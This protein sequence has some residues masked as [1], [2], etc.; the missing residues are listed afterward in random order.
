MLY[1]LEVG[2]SYSVP[3]LAGSANIIFANKKFLE[4]AGLEPDIVPAD[5][6]EFL[7]VMT[8]VKEATDLGITYG[9][10]FEDLLRGWVVNPL[11]I[12]ACGPEHYTSVINGDE[13]FSFTD[14]CVRN[15]Y[16]FIG[17]ITERDLWMP[18][19]QQL[20]IDEAD[21]AFTQEKAAFLVGG[22]YTLG[23]LI[24]QG[25]PAEDIHAFAQPTL[26]DAIQSPMVLSPFSLIDAMVT[27][28]SLHPEIA[29]DFLAF[30]VQPEQMAVFAEITGDFPATMLEADP[31]VIGEVMASLVTMYQSDEPSLLASEDWAPKAAPEAW[32]AADA[33]CNKQ[34]T[35]EATLDEL[36]EEADA[37][38]Q[39]DKE[40]REGG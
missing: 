12:T 1:T 10:K 20:L 40:V 30:M 29:K 15:A 25:M 11:A 14:E 36:L 23:F 7:D 18:G 28:N 37:A 9:G 34:I 3:M 38:A 8:T 17:D 31:E 32:A 35:G 24:A 26:P 27:S 4:E 13:G 21:V 39:Y 22:S 19:V 2:Q 16:K 5:T 6:E 33:I